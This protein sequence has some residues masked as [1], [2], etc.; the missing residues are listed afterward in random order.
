MDRYEDLNGDGFVESPKYI[1]RFRDHVW[2]SDAVYASPKE[3]IID[4][5]LKL[6]HSPDWLEEVRSER[7]SV[8]MGPGY[9]ANPEYVG[10]VN[11]SRIGSTL[12]CGGSPREMLD[13]IKRFAEKMRMRAGLE[14]E[15]W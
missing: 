4:I 11:R 1:L 13:C 10:Q 6:G 2:G 3:M 15:E 8:E 7:W 5:A 9:D 12:D 14:G